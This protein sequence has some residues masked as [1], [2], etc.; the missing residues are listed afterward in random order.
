MVIGILLASLVDAPTPRDRVMAAAL[1]LH[2]WYPAMRDHGMR[3]MGRSRMSSAEDGAAVEAMPT[4]LPSQDAQSCAPRP[5]P[6]RINV[7]PPFASP[8]LRLADAVCWGLEVLR[9]TRCAR[10]AVLGSFIAVHGA[11]CGPL[12]WG[13]ATGTYGATVMLDITAYGFHHGH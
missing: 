12:A 13:A 10:R 8:A 6:H 5:R 7:C 9:S 2:P 11:W 1:T 4:A 3:T